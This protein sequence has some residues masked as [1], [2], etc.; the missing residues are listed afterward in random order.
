MKKTTFC[1]FSLMS[2]SYHL[3][4]TAEIFV[5][6]LLKLFQQAKVLVITTMEEAEAQTD[7][8]MT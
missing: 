8:G 4:L 5:E 7:R 6:R 2:G 3:Y 1:R